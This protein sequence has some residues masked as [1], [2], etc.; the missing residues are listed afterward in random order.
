[1]SFELDNDRTGKQCNSNDPDSWEII[2]WMAGSSERLRLLETMSDGPVDLVTVADEQERAPLTL[3]QDVVAMMLRGWV[4]EE[5]T[6]YRTTASGRL[7][8][9]VVTTMVERIDRIADLTP[10]LSHL[11]GTGALEIG[12]IVDCTVTT[13][14]PARP[15]R[16]EKRLIERY[17]NATTVRG[18]FP[19]FPAVLVRK[20]LTGARDSRLDVELI[21]PEGTIVT[22]DDRNRI[23]R[24][25]TEL[26][27]VVIDCFVCED[28]PPYAVVLVDDGVVLVAYDDVGRVQAIVESNATRTIEW[29]TACYDEYRRHA[30][31]AENDT[32]PLP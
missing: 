27:R 9:D 16:A 30:R 26:D 21:L 25:D 19:V 22:T 18:L 5:A 24:I 15:Y 28:P 10:F 20:C 3:Q 7:L 14:R 8:A 32:P 1:M 13:A 23:D 2:E 4:T 11:D 17:A 12:R 29:A 6:G 31:P